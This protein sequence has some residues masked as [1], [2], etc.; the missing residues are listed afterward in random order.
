MP[1][2]L[3]RE[4]DAAAVAA[5]Y[6][7]FVAGTPVSFETVP[8]D[9]P[10][11]AIRIRRALETHPWLVWDEDGRVTG[12]AYAGPHRAR[13]AYRWGVDVSAYVAAAAR[14]AGVGRALYDTLF[15]VLRAQGFHDAYAGITLPNPPS[16]AFHE[17]MGFTPVG[18]YR[19]VGYKLGEWHDVGWWQR[20]VGDHAPDPSEPGP[21]AEALRAAGVAA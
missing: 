5:L 7:P 6:A 16:V 18:V 10:E 9:E 8:P 14:R 1:V 2:R 15:R 11:M 12:Y 4:P 3:A 17:A 21:L 20:A 19:R 13:A